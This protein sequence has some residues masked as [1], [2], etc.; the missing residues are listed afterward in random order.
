MEN[1]YNISNGKYE[2]I[3][4]EINS[5]AFSKIYN[6]KNNSNKNNKYIVKIQKII[7]R[8]EAINEI[9]L[10]QKL[11][12]NKNDYL[13]NI[14]L[15]LQNKVKYYDISKIIDIEDFY[16]DSN[17]IYI[18]FKKY[19]LSLDEFHILYQKTFKEL[20]P[21]N[22]I[23]KLTNSL[24]LGLYE[25]HTSNI[26]HCDIKPNN[27]MVYSNTKSIKDLFKDIKKKK[28]NKNELI[29]YIDLVFIDFNLSQKCKSICKSIKI[30]TTYYMSPEIIL[31]NCNFTRSID[32]WSVGCIIYELLTG[33]FLFDIYNYNNKY[34]DYY[35][36]FSLESHENTTSYEYSYEDNNTKLNKDNLILLYLYREL[37]GDNNYLIG[38]DIT[39]YYSNQLLIGTI[40]LKETNNNNFINYIEKNIN[41]S[42]KDIKNNYINILKDIF[43]Y[44]FNTRLSIDDYFNKYIFII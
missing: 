29:H 6:I 8:Y 31:G 15:K 37:F 3:E 9:K 38:N 20:L 23:Q 11:K 42:S 10:L 43:I 44:N 1:I 18:V 21:L 32:I 28:I 41:I 16:N 13:K 14:S 7:D 27:I 34:G 12:N 22:L 24:F 17:Y 33:K 26:I 4:T 19:E 36:N 30:Q 25:L 40:S 2:I 39:K 35:N 5:G